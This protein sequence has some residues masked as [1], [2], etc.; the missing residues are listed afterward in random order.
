MKRA[1]LA[2]LAA[3][4][5]WSLPLHAQVPGTVA[6]AGRLADDGQA[7]TAAFPMQFALYAEAEGG[8]PLWQETH[9]SVDV[10]DGRFFVALGSVTP[11]GDVFNGTPL[12]LEV[13]VDGNA[14]TPRLAVQSVPYAVRAGSAVVADRA[15]TADRLG[16]HGPDDFLTGLQAT[17]PL[18]VGAG[19]QPTISL[20]PCQEN[21]ILQFVEGQW[22]CRAASTFVGPAGERGEPGPAGPQGAEGPQGPVG[23]QGESVTL[24]EVAPGDAVCPEGGSRFTVGN[25]VTYACH[26]AVG[27]TGAQGPVGPQGPQGEVG[28]V[29][30]Q[31]ESVLA[32]ELLPGDAVCP[33]GG[34][35]FTVGSTVTYACHGAT[36]PVG[37]QGPQGEV[38]PQGPVGPQGES[39]TSEEVVPGDAVCPEGGSRFTVG[40]TVT[41][42]C[43]GAVGATGAQGPQGE[44]GPQG[45][46]GPQGPTGPQGESVL[47]EELLPGD[48]VCLDGGTRF[49][50]GNTV[51]YAC[52]GAAGPVG[53][54]GP[55]GEVGPQGEQGPQ[56]PVGPQGES[57][58]SEEVAPGDAVCPEGG[59]RFTVGNTV[60]YACHGAV[61]ATGAQGPVGPQ[62]PQGEVGPVGPQGESVLAEDLLPGDPV[63]PNGGARFTVGSTVTYACHG[64]TG[65]V[66]AQGPQGATGA[67]GPQGPVGP[68]GPQGPAGPQGPQGDV[69]PQ[70]PQGPTGSQGPQGPVGPQG[71]AGSANISGTTNR[72]VKFTASTTGGDS[73]ISDDGTTISISGPL[74]LNGGSGT[75]SAT[76]PLEISSANTPRISFKWNSGT[77][78][79]LGVDSGG[80]VRTYDSAGTGYAPLAASNIA[81]NGFLNVVAPSDSSGNLRF[82]AANPYIVA[83]SYVIIPGGAYF[84]SGTVYHEAQAQFRGGIH[85]DSNSFLT[86]AGGTSGTTYVSGN[87]GIGTTGPSEQVH[88]T[89]NVRAD[90]AVIWGTL[91]SRTE[92]KDD[93]GALATRSGFFETSAPVNAYPGASSWQHVLD[94]RHSNNANNYALQVAGS[95][96]DQDLWF[97]KTNNSGTTSWSQLVAAG[98]RPCT[99]PFNGLGVTMT[100]SNNG[101]TRSNTLCATNWIPPQNF[102]SAQ[103]TCA[104]LGGHIS[105]YHEIYQLASA[106]GGV[107]AVALNGDWIGNRAGDD[108]ALCV[109]G[110]DI[111][112]F[113]GICNKNNSQW[114]RCVSSS[115]YTP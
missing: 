96:F 19:P 15:L 9:A 33:D 107:A 106:N 66:G 31:G 80:A 18:L 48:A 5:L 2:I 26:G 22:A 8:N 92:T 16:E 73:L 69:G 34:A 24:E 82:T 52:H 1:F 43:H 112:N 4:T 97:R 88:A 113:D 23:P 28:P 94:V 84:N 111:N 47:A 108:E 109:N 105:T 38:G 77:T 81:A 101:V 46:E 65:P 32:E 104:A 57:V 25:T 60:T 42:A 20:G 64:A 17:A 85:N 10:M 14:M 61:G 3:L 39:V 110:T 27:A 6:F 63:C 30:P 58:T 76:A 103:T 45:P 70:G 91:Q 99:A 115:T 90:G 114:F 55:Q 7:V 78:A 49:T 100:A 11:L 12:F 87:L 98:P 21:E 67:Q 59:S 44:V 56:G 83:S 13:V 72:L 93:L 89:G 35:R 79:Q 29:G 86:L 53:A 74:R 51:T 40:N 41:Y 54:Q 68:Q 50:V 95:F 36:G 71:P 62:G 75:A 102:V 37:A